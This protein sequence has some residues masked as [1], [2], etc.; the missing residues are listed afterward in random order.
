MEIPL[1]IKYTD[2]GDLEFISLCS[3]LDE[4]LNAIAGGEEHRQQ[5]IPHNVP[6]GVC[7]VILV[8]LQN[9]CIGC[10]ALKPYAHGVA[11][12]KRVF[13]L[14]EYRRHGAGRYLMRELER[15]A[16]R[17]GIHTLRLETGAPLF[18]AVALYSAMGYQPAEKYGPYAELPDT[19]DCI[20]M[21]KKLKKEGP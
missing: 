15:V 8:Y 5:Y 1:Q 12:V 21:A 10:A 7:A 19:G 18:E 16:E 14:P 4:Y 20:C 6:S 13:V 9:R 3:Q 11:E 17:H 2:G